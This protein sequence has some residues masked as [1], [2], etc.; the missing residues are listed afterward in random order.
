M[1]GLRPGRP[2]LK[3]H[4]IRLYLKNFAE[5]HGR[6][7]NEKIQIEREKLGQAKGR[8]CHFFRAVFG[9]SVKIAEILEPVSLAILVF[10]TYNEFWGDYPKIHYR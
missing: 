1:E 9:R 10:F 2:G 3:T 5:V 8:F 6:S 4:W 7:K